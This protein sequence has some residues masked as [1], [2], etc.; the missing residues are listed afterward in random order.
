MYINELLYRNFFKESV[1]EDRDVD[2]ADLISLPIEAFAPDNYRLAMEVY[3]TFSLPQAFDTGAFEGL[4]QFRRD[5]FIVQVW[6][7]EKYH[8][9][10][11]IHKY[12]NLAWMHYAGNFILHDEDLL[13]CPLPD[14]HDIFI[15]R[16]AYFLE[17]AIEAVI[18]VWND[19]A[20]TSEQIKTIS[21]RAMEYAVKKTDA[22]Y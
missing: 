7:G 10:Y 17:Y 5:A 18:D 3:R 21:E 22:I 9:A 12:R 14:I 1:L 19:S 2:V 11:N 6:A 4:D 13:V 15:A 20:L 8:S 16:E